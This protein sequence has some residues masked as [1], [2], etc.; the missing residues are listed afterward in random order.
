MG[1][2]PSEVRKWG[3]EQGYAVSVKGPI[4]IP[5]AQKYYEAHKVNTEP[6]L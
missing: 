5:L 1:A 3:R 2:K 4:S 6:D